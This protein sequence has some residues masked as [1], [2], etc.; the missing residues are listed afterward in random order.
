MPRAP[1]RLVGFG[2]ACAVGGLG[3]RCVAAEAGMFY[4]VVKQDLPTL[5]VKTLRTGQG[6]AVLIRMLKTTGS[7]L[8]P[9][10]KPALP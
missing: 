8:D 1:P 10:S 7:W 2:C 9:C 3:S 4:R 6:A 5:Q